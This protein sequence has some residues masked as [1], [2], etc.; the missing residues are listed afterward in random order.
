ME[1]GTN[2]GL[3]LLEFCAEHRLCVTNTLFNNK[4]EHKTT[5][6]S[7]DGA[8]KNLIDYVIVNR[9]RKIAILDTRVYRGCKLPYDN[10][11]AISKVR[12]KL[13]AYRKPAIN[14]KPEMD[15]LKVEN[16]KTRYQRLSEI[17]LKY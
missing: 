3:R 1:R 15:R 10:K 7:L 2:N 5:W 14:K 12:I 16:V 17:D 8:T 4:V 11:L 6:T 9:A 13:K